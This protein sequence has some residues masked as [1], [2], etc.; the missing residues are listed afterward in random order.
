[1]NQ[2]EI[3]E[4]EMELEGGDKVQMRIQESEDWSEIQRGTK[5]LIVLVNGQKML[6]NVNEACED[7]GVSFNILG[8]KRRYHYDVEVVNSIF[9]E[10]K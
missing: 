5:A 3:L 7:K 6:V 1:M 4:V 8:D 10:V 9:T 2:N